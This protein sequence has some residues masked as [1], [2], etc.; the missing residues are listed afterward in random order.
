MGTPQARQ[1]EA[2][3]TPAAARERASTG[4]SGEIQPLTRAG[5]GRWCRIERLDGPPQS[6]R[7]LLDLG[8]TPGEEL[9]V[10]QVVPLGGPVVVV[11]RGTRLALRRE[12]AAWVLV[13]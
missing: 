7:R 3:A 5:R 9:S 8:L 6:C 10:V 13:R 12:E 4:P 1:A 2:P 11:V